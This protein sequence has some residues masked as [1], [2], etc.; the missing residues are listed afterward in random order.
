MSSF[1]NVTKAI[2]LKDLICELRARQIL[3]PVIM[4]GILISWI[5]RIIT[6]NTLMDTSVIAAAVL[7]VAILF[8]AILSSERIFALEQQND[9]INALVLAPADA[10][11]IYIAKLLVNITMLCIFEIVAVPAVFLLFNISLTGDWLRLITTLMLINIGVSGA[12][13]LLGCTVQAA[14][15]PNS[16]LSVLVMAVLSPMMIPAVFALLLLVGPVNARM[17]A[18]GM[19]TIVGDFKTAAGFLTAFDAILVAVSWMLFGFI[20][21]EEK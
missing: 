9:C 8:A 17:P 15:A 20:M 21:A 11:D 3:P 16:L 2:F 13:T 7:L 4:L 1:L 5:F 19:L 18:A 10:G 12:G 14:R 6:E